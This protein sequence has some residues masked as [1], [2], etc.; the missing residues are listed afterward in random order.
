MRVEI[1]MHVMERDLVYRDGDG[2]YDSFKMINYGIE[3][4]DDGWRMIKVYVNRYQQKDWRGHC[5]FGPAYVPFKPD[6]LIE[7]RL[8]MSVFYALDGGIYQEYK[9]INK[10][11]AILETS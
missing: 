6:S 5:L 1:P 9:W 11:W 4:L 3:R 8:S 10:I 2:I 7:K